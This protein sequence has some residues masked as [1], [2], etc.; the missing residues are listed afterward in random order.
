M[1]LDAISLSP[2]MTG[3]DEHKI[4]FECFITYGSVSMESIDP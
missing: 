3:R 4:H 1:L 2:N